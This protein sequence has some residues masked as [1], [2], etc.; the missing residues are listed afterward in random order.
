GVHVL[1]VIDGQAGHPGRTWVAVAAAARRAASSGRCTARVRGASSARAWGGLC[2]QVTDWV[3][4]ERHDAAR[5]RPEQQATRQH[6]SESASQHRSDR[7]T[8][9]NLKAAGERK[10]T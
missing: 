8:Q 6:E 4:V 7:L 1:E 2:A 3:V 5:Q 9:N 10:K